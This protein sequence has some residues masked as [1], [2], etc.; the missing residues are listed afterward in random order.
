MPRPKDG[1]LAE[2]WEAAKNGLLKARSLGGRFYRNDRGSHQEI[3]DMTLDEISLC[4][5]AIEGNSFATSVK[6]QHVKCVAGGYVP[7]EH[8][9]E[10]KAVTGE[11]AGWEY[12]ATGLA[13][14][15]QQ[16]R[17]L[18]AL[19]VAVARATLGIRSHR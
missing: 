15:R 16:T 18:E 3:H 11:F 7:V 1:T 14:E 12:L 5:V 17:D 4:P 2:I 9:A 19:Q 13:A 8:Y 10:Y 6:P